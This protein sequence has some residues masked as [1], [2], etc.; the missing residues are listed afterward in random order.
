[1][2]ISKGGL[3]VN[4]EDALRLIG[5]HCGGRAIGDACQRDLS[6]FRP[7]LATTWKALEDDCYVCLIGNSR[8]ALTR[9]G[10]VKALEATGNLCNEQMKKDLG[11]LSAVLKDRLERTS[12]PA[13]VGTHE[14][15]SETRLPHYWVVNA[16]HSHLIAHCLKRRD[17]DWAPGDR[18]ESLIEVP[19]NF[20]HPIYDT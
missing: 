7:I 11:R 4:K 17:A 13:L 3:S 10:W 20:G 9:Q 15:V 16:I 19:I 2:T 12:G 18:M 8:F 5:E 14:V 6:Q 1:M